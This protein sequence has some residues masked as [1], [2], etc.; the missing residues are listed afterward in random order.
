MTTDI[1]IP[2]INTL[3]LLPLI[4]IVGFLIFSII[5][6]S[7]FLF[8]L[9]IGI[10]ISIMLSDY[11]KSITPLNNYTR[12]P[13]PQPCS[14]IPGYPPNPSTHQLEVGI[15]SSPVVALIFITTTWLLMT[16]SI[17]Q[18]T[19]WFSVSFLVMWVQIYSECNTIEQVLI[20]FLMGIFLGIIF[21]LLLRS[22]GTT[23][24]ISIS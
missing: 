21:Y 4:L 19:F 6:G 14:I 1:T 10:I 7:G 11:I 17:E 2:L 8:L 23:Y 15:P 20:G 18:T 9:S 12:R 13:F 3:Q 24:N 5:Y 16:K 22:L